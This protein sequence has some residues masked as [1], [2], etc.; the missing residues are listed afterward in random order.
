MSCCYILFSPSLQSSYIGITQLEI[1][2][3]LE[4]HTLHLYGIKYT[5]KTNDWEVF[6]EISCSNISQSIKIE[7]HLKSMKSKVYIENLKKYPEMIQK[8]LDKFD[9]N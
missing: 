1:N 4:K 9:G 5:S 8:I 2:N 3:R 7:K 6:L